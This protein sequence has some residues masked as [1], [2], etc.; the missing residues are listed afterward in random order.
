MVI[1]ITKF[2][3][4]NVIDT[5]SIWNMLSSSILYDAVKRRECNFTC[6]QFVIY[7]CLYKKRNQTYDHD[8]ELMKRLKDELKNN[9][10]A[11]YQISIE[12][13]QNVEILENRMKLSKGELSSI[14]FAKKTRQAFLTDDQ[15]ARKLA[16]HII[17]DNSMVQTIPHLLGWIVYLGEI[18]DMSF[19]KI[20][21][22]HKSFN[23]PLEKYF[24]EVFYKALELR[25]V[26]A[27]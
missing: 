24:R 18:N 25:L 3:K 14:V 12:D 15:A 26:N 23:R 20:V 10:I 13:L 2:N 27:Q 16:Y 11:Q 8:K 22:E 1:D 4:L 9:A 7:E 21:S 6:T 19:E 5:C 17:I